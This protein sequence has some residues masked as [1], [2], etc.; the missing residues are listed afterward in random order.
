MSQQLPKLEDEILRKI[1]AK[2]DPKTATKSKALSKRWKQRLISLLFAKHKYRENKDK[3]MQVVATLA[4][5]HRGEHCFSMVRVDMQTKQQ[6][7]GKVPKPIRNFSSF[8]VIGSS[9]GLICVK[10]SLGTIHSE[11]AVWNLLT[12]TR[13]FTIHDHSSK[14]KDFAVSQYA[15]GHIFYLMYYA[16]VHVFK[17]SYSDRTLSWTL[18]SSI[19]K[20]G[21][22]KGVVYWIG[23]QGVA[24]PKPKY[25]VSFNLRNRAW[26]EVDILE[27]VKSRF[28]TLSIVKDEVAFV[29]SFYETQFKTVV[30][31]YQ[32]TRNG[33]FGSSWGKLFRIPHMGVPFTPTMF[34][35]K[36]MLNVVESRSGPYNANDADRTDLLIAKHDY[37]ADRSTNLLRTS[38]AEIV[39]LKTVILHSP[40]MYTVE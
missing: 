36:Y 37:E 17:K 18:Y 14:Y 27:R 29:S 5:P 12:C 4:R 20:T 22:A 40:G 26:L 3:N 30:D 31:V 25:I 33:T 16:I 6:C 9:N 39:H 8:Q 32:V 35:G 34:I 10:F 23:W 15:F 21:N 2:A 13:W 1:F 11:L 24:I 28:H 7:E 38:W 19:A